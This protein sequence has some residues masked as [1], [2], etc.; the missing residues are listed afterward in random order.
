MGIDS[1]YNKNRE[2]SKYYLEKYIDIC[3]KIL[4]RLQKDTPTRRM[5]WVTAATM[6]YS[7][8]NFE[9]KVTEM[10]DQEYLMVFK[11]DYA[12]C[13]RD[14]LYGKS[15]EYFYGV[16]DA[17]DLD[18]ALL[19]SSEKEG[20][21]LSEKERYEYLPITKKLLIP[22]LRLA[23]IPD[24]QLENKEIENLDELEREFPSMYLYLEHSSK[25]KFTRNLK[26]GNP[27]IIE[28]NN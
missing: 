17:I 11:R 6:A 28:K 12:H 16:D 2:Q 3:N 1:Q 27:K 25:Y 4:E 24:V 8:I 23:A 13:L 21:C 19:K 22:I 18:E 14:F 15:P 7:S 5:A 20:R 9:N 26:T 10:V